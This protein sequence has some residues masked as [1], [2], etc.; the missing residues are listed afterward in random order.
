[1]PDAPLANLPPP[2]ASSDE[3]LTRFLD[4]VAAQG[5][6][7][8]P[9]QEE[10]L[11]ELLDGKHVVLSTPTGSGK[12]LVAIALH[13]LA[14]ARGQTS[15]YTSPIKALVNEKF[16]ALCDA[17]GPAKVG[18][19]TG[20][21]S[22][23]RD[24]PILCCTAEIL[25][26]VALR[27]GAAARADAV[28][29]DEFHYF[30]DRDRGM[31]WQIPLLLLEKTQFLLMSAT[32]GDTSTLEAELAKV[33]GRAVSAVRG[34]TRPV[35][36]HFSYATTPLHETIGDLVSA[37][38]APIYVVNFTQRAAADTAQ[39]MTSL[40]LTTRDEKDA[41]RE[42][43]FDFR[44]DTPHGKELQ[45]LLRAGIGVHHAG[46]LPKYRRLVEKLAQANKLKLVSGT[47]T[48]GVGVNVP[49]RTVLFTQLCKFDGEK[50]VVLSSRDFHQIAGRAGRRGFDA[51][52]FVVAEA[53]EHV[54]ENLALARKEA[55][56]KKK[57]PRKKPPTKGYVHFDEATFERLRAG[58]P[59]PLVGRFEVTHGLVLSLLQR[60][61]PAEVEGVPVADESGYA[62]LLTLIS[63]AHETDYAKRKLKRR[64]ATL[65]RQLR[66]AELVRVVSV[67]GTTSMRRRGSLLE[68]SP[69]LQKEFSLHHT[70]SLWLV[71]T[72]PKLDPALETYPLDVLSLVESI[73]ESPK[74]VLLKQVD[75]A[76]GEKVAEL[77]AQGMEYEERMAEL[78]KVEHPKPL[79]DFVYATFNAFAE[80]HPWVGAEN[81]RPKSIARE[82]AEKAATFN[83]YVRDYQLERSEGV[84]LRYL[85]DAW[86]T[87]TQS[88]PERHRDERVLDL[89]EWLRVSVRAVDASLL[90][91]WEQ[92]RNP[93]AILARAEHR[94]PPV[95]KV[96]VAADPRAF[97][98]RV[99]AELHRL[100]AA[101][102]ARD[103]EEAAACIKDP[104]GAWTPERFAAETAA[105]FE[106]HGR[107]DTTPRARLAE[108]TRLVPDGPRRW[109]ATQRLLAPDTA[110]DLSGEAQGGREAQLRRAAGEGE[111]DVPEGSAD[112][113]MLDCEV[114][115]AGDVDADRPLIALRR[116][117]M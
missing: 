103:W 87:L 55:A 48:L 38:R 111:A 102:A 44:F 15:V 40:N 51:E 58:T 33:T 91:E 39:A 106:E 61:G 22:I 93:E 84:L 11:L 43:L 90:E 96:D 110:N 25:A 57:A 4:Y 59:E 64:A 10:A 29:M 17:F 70:L 100:V 3:L 35:P 92:L 34:A 99:R 41:L 42:A 21:A 47:D 2:G 94:P 116:I 16:F 65:V 9:A 117:G 62:R 19:L 72:L 83:E 45:R 68:V 75:K 37:N 74:I 46:L 36:L 32:L 27:E 73:L 78:E 13:Y 20:D 66:K 8:Y 53:P 113:W 71:D 5:L 76:K 7:L 1:M 105:F 63:R 23:N 24:A 115:L 54:I 89:L 18:M 67:A 88:V 108:H 69:D 81:V 82:L 26:N 28:V 52:G 14:L 50:V 79:G 109:L 112:L 97:L 6:Q 107:V 114:D 60:R 86:R 77:K 30:A 104:D 85:S 31:A 101:V 80:R 95:R 98:A 56:G 49:L 12:S